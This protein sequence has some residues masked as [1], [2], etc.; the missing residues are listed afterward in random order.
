MFIEVLLI[1]ARKWK[2]PKCAS[3]NEWIN[4]MCNDGILLRN[5]KE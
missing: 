2:Q 4:K 3:T 5:K 1:I